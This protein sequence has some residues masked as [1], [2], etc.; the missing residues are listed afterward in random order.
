MDRGG[1]LLRSLGDVFGARLAPSPASFAYAGGV[2]PFAFPSQPQAA[3]SLPRRGLPRHHRL[4]YRLERLAH[5]RYLGSILVVGLFAGCLL[6]GAVQGGGYRDFVEAQ[7][8]IP[9]ILA[10]AAGFDVKSVSIAGAQELSESELLAIA[11]VRPRNSLL[12]LDAAALRAR[13]KAIPLIKE[14]SV[15]KLY[16]NRLMIEVE[17]RKPFALWQKDG[18]VQLVAKDGTPIDDM[19]DARFEKLPLVVG[20]GANAQ[21]ASYVAILE[22]AGE[23]RDRIRAG[24]YV[25]GRRWTLKMD[26]GIEIALPEENPGEAVAH[27]AG[28]EHDG[29]ILEKDVV[30]LD[31]RMPDRVV[32][33][34]SADAAA[35][36]E[37]SLAKKPKK[38][39]AQT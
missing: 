32:A 25:S 8:T 37:E 21:V 24:M 9:D 27:L 36:R 13:L 22:D 29:Q 28:L 26:N 18:M 14:A 3:P 15:S 34:L 23:L 2:D 12:L 31:L 19:H 11:G 16:P 4:R 39:G 10:R 6:A 17:E 1:R 35:A 33:R 20:D 7:G 30:S 5:A 38:K